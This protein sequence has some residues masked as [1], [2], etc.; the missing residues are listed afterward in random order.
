MYIC[1]CYRCMQ[2]CCTLAR[3]M[4]VSI[5][6]SVEGPAEG[7]L[8]LV[9][10][11]VCLSAAAAVTAAAA[12]RPV[13]CCCGGG[14]CAAAWCFGGGIAAAV[15]TAAAVLPSAA[16]VAQRA[17][18]HFLE[19]ALALAPRGFADEA[20]V[21]MGLTQPDGAAFREYC[22][23]SVVSVI[24]VTH[25]YVCAN[26]RPAFWHRRCCALANRWCVHVRLYVDCRPSV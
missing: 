24:R 6:I 11:V 5:K 4:Q 8:S 19:A 18:S 10:C 15:N 13:C 12:L 14:G 20:C 16:V 26:C 3:T 25:A 23:D 21:R 17:G 7:L 22:S 2:R 9:V 1:D